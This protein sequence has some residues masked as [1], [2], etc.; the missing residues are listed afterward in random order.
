MLELKQKELNSNHQDVR[1]FRENKEI[2][3]LSSLY[4][5]IKNRNQSPQYTAYHIKEM[6]SVQEL[7]KPR[8]AVQLESSIGYKYIA[9]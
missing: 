4:E 9:F 8:S 7:Q 2:I 1:K 3:F 6:F 5:C